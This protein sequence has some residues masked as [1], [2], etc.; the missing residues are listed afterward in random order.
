MTPRYE[1]LEEQVLSARTEGGSTE[2]NVKTK[3][4]NIWT[5][6]H[7]TWIPDEKWMTQKLII[8]DVELEQSECVGGLDLAQVYEIGR[9]HV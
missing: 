8:P 6:T 4:F 7:S 5:T 2:V 9:A 1:Y 3:N